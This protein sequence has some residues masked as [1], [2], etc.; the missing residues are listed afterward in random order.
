MTS[1]SINSSLAT[2]VFSGPHALSGWAIMHV[3]SKPVSVAA[4]NTGQIQEYISLQA[5]NNTYVGMHW[6]GNSWQNLTQTGWY[7]DPVNQLLYVHF[8]GDR[9][10]ILSVMSTT[11]TQSGSLNI[12]MPQTS[13]SIM[14]GTN[15]TLMFNVYSTNIASQLVT[16]TSSQVPAGVYVKIS[17]YASYTNFSSTLLI[18]VSNTTQPGSYYLILEA[19]SSTLFTSVIITLSVIAAQPTGQGSSGNGGS[20]S[21]QSGSNTGQLSS[22]L[23]TL[24]ILSGPAVLGLHRLI[25][26]L[27]S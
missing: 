1:Y 4:S 16:L 22:K 11:S 14:Q 19:N 12:S 24:T 5:L 2:Y 26:E 23:Y 8:V 25:L 10:V 21:N 18:S 17:P 6:N 7:Y 13:V 3:W 15:S 27:I 20:A 9:K